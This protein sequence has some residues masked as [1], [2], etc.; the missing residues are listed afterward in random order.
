MGFLNDQIQTQKAQNIYIYYQ[1]LLFFRNAFFKKYYL[2]CVFFLQK[3]EFNHYAYS[4]REFEMIVIS[5]V[6]AV[7]HVRLATIYRL[8]EE[9]NTGCC[10]P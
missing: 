9:E 7:L 8:R 4:N 1:T 10:S 6:L 3:C 5:P 2:A